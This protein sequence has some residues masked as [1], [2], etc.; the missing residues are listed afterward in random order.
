MDYLKLKYSFVFMKEEVQINPRK[1][2]ISEEFKSRIETFY[3]DFDSSLDSLE[4]QMEESLI[5]LLSQLQIQSSVKTNKS[6]LPYLYEISKTLILESYVNG[7]TEYERVF[8]EIVFELL[9]NKVKKIRFYVFIDLYDEKGFF[10]KGLTYKFR[11]YVHNKIDD[12]NNYKEI[13]LSNL[14]NVILP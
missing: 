6:S 3:Q 9:K 2:E 1:R 11:Y 4:Q 13:D 10:N 5:K 8:P 7:F 14:T 12:E